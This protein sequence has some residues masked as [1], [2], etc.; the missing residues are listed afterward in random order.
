MCGIFGYVGNIEKSIALKCS[1]AIRHRGPD[2]DGIVIFDNAVLAHRRLSIFDLSDNASQP[3]SYANKRYWITYN[4]EIYNF[5]ELRNELIDLGFSF[6]SKSDTEVILAA[7]Q[8]WGESC[9]NRFN[10][11]WAFA[12]WDTLA[13]TL[14]LSRDRFG[15]KP[16]FYRF[17]SNNEFAFCSEMKGLFPLMDQVKANH[18]IVSNISGYMNYESTEEC[19]IEGIIRFPAGS[20]G[21]F[22][23]GKLSIKRWWNTLD[24]LI[25]PP[26]RYEDQVEQFKELF[27]DACKL[28]M[29]SDV[30][31]GTALSGGLDSSASFSCMASLGSE[32]ATSSLSSSWQH[33]FVASFPGSPLDEVEYAKEVALRY[34]VKPTIVEIDPLS[35]IN[36]LNEYMYLQEDP[37]I[38]SPI[39]FMQLYRT[40]KN[41]GISVTIDGHGADELFGGYSFD[42][43]H[44]L[45]DC[46]FNDFKSKEVIKTFY[47][48]HG[49][50]PQLIPSES[51][52][53]LM[54]KWQA[55][56]IIRK[57]A[58]WS[59]KPESFKLDNLNLKLYESTHNSILPTLLRNYDRYSMSSGV[60]I[61][62]PFMD[63][64]IVTFAFSIPWTSKVRGGYSKSII[65]DALRDII[66]EKIVNRKEKIGFNSPVVEWMKG[67]LKPFLLD[68]IS[69]RGFKEST[70]INHIEVKKLILEAINNENT[71]FQNAT[72]AWMKLT[73]YLWEKAMLNKAKYRDA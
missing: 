20:C 29:R 47:E 70:L 26:P 34:K 38:T 25:T 64:R 32:N 10:G 4:G 6:K 28:R 71:N 19:A 23:Q 35:D 37:Y 43:I 44:A 51:K 59:K 40:V 2:G 48:M 67:P 61:R 33:A 72:L 36:A 11:M 69:D 66:P 60:E 65:R 30:P 53:R 63:H 17:C 24:N 21:W 57:M 45:Y 16:L 3:M 18:K 14:F 46:S 31:I 42:L 8:I 52:S 58:I 27:Y 73:P 7:Y 1:E 9:Q 62:M 22:S 49:S 55:K 54:F 41:A 15:K 68:T 56:K 13:K 50:S 39:P 12:I 5:Y